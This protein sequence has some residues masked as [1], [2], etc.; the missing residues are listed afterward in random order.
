M[1]NSQA[2]HNTHMSEGRSKCRLRCRENRLRTSFRH[3]IDTAEKF[4]LNG[5]RRCNSMED[6]KGI[7]DLVTSA[8]EPTRFGDV[9]SRRVFRHP[10]DDSD[11][12]GSVRVV[13][14]NDS[15]RLGLRKRA[16]ENTA[17]TPSTESLL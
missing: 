11:V 2:H 3:R 1:G 14:R 15:F 8:K 16:L 10:D 4:T 7:N 12:K 5:S 13:D 17:T 9:K 6:L